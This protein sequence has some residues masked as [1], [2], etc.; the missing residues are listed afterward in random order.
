MDQY[1]VKVTDKKVVQ[2]PMLL[3]E[4]RTV[5]PNTG[6]PPEQMA[7]HGF[8]IVDI[9]YDPEIQEIDFQ[10]PVVDKDGKVTYPPKDR[11]L[12]DVKAEKI[13]KIRDTVLS[14]VFTEFGRDRLIGMSLGVYPD[15]EAKDRVQELLAGQQEAETAVSTASKV[16]DVKA[17]E[18]AA[19]AVKVKPSA[20]PK[21]QGPVA[22]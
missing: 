2:Q 5:S 10:A 7:L 8:Q 19:I 4:D 6:W 18:T 20:L 9:T 16:Q 15:K 22:G 11:P 12:A 13:Q 14:T 3:S 17:V 21:D 1:Y